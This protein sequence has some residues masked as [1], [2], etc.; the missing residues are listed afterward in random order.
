MD[1]PGHVVHDLLIIKIGQSVRGA[2]SVRPQGA[3]SLAPCKDRQNGQEQGLDAHLAVPE[4]RGTPLSLS[5]VSPAL[6]E[7][8]P[9]AAGSLQET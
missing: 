8:F 3:M 5:V 2:N 4:R 6:R 9:V 1:K 7:E